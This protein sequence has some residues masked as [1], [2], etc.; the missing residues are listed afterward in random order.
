[1]LKAFLLSKRKCSIDKTEMQYH[2]IFN[3]KTG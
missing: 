1:M 2:N 3:Y